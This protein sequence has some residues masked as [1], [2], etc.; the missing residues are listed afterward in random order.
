MSAFNH[1]SAYTEF[2]LRR[3]TT[4][5]VGITDPTQ[6]RRAFVW[7]EQQGRS[8][9]RDDRWSDLTVPLS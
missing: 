8:T 9:V 7:L 1:Y 2:T 5:L 4:A 3:F 6:L